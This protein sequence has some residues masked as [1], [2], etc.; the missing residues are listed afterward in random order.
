M[1]PLAK[2]HRDLQMSGLF[3]VMTACFSWA[4][5]LL[6]T[7][8]LQPCES[9]ARLWPE[10]SGGPLHRREH[11]RFQCCAEPLCTV[12]LELFHLLACFAPLLVLP[13]GVSTASP[14]A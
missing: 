9:V 11:T 13:I 7:P 2:S 10:D 4:T 1:S 3:S 6:D 12:T 14:R 8:C 5:R